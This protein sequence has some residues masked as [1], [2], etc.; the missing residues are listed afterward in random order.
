MTKR[1]LLERDGE[2]ADL[3]MPV[4]VLLDASEIFRSSV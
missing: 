3:R 4:Q 1:V 2:G